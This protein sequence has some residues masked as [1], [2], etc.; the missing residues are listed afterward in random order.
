VEEEEAPVA[1]SHAD[2][3]GGRLGSEG[4]GGAASAAC[5]RLTKSL[6]VPEPG[7]IGKG[8]GGSGSWDGPTGT[9]A[10]GGGGRGTSQRE[11]R[12]AIATVGDSGSAH[13]RKGDVTGGASPRFH[14]RLPRQS[15]TGASSSPARATSAQLPFRPRPAAHDRVFRSVC[16]PPR[17]QQQ[18][19]NSASAA[20][21]RARASDE[22]QAAPERMHAKEMDHGPDT[23]APAASDGSLE[24]KFELIP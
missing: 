2:L 15:H 13:Q 24:R 18:H 10:T 20:P 19:V 7:G 4:T 3:T 8:W 22:R 1:N 14:P 16:L 17:L 23:A 12:R 5:Q 6:A 21:P 9:A 11:G